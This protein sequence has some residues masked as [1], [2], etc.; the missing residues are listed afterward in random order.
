MIIEAIFTWA[1]RQPATLAVA[2]PGVAL[3]YAAL[4]HAVR[5]RASTLAGAGQSGLVKWLFM[6]H[7][8]ILS[9]QNLQQADKIIAAWKVLGEKV[10]WRRWA[11]PC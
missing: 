9:L 10:G 7:D 2:T 4:V 6:G 5:A 11:A 3:D 8:G 1:E